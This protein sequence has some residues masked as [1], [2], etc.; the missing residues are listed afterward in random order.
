MVLRGLCGMP[1]IEP[2]LA[3]RVPCRLLPCSTVTS[4]PHKGI[5]QEDRIAAVGREERGWWSDFR[6]QQCSG[7]AP[8]RVTVSSVK[9]CKQGLHSTV[10]PITLSLSSPLSV[11]GGHQSH[12]HLK[13]I[14]FLFGGVATTLAVLLTLCSEI[15]PD[16]TWG[17]HTECWRLNL[18]RLFAQRASN[19]L[20][21]S[22]LPFEKS[23][24]I[25]Y[26]VSCSDKQSPISQPLGDQI[27]PIG[28]PPGRKIGW[29]V[30]QV[31]SKPLGF[32]KGP[33]SPA[34]SCWHLTHHLHWVAAHGEAGK[35][36]VTM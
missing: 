31:S 15:T 29:P 9:C 22:L 8:S 3:G 34:G 5:F 28:P 27:N 24:F 7:F 32:L 19:V 1:G 6:Q 23:F 25:W 36:R 18:D 14:S 13:I 17:N 30:E 33:Q 16:G 26:I 4:V 2:W 35:G 10:S 20:S 21:F 11:A 12:L